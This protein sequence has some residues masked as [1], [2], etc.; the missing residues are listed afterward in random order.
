MQVTVTIETG[1]VCKQ[2]IDVLFNFNVSARHKKKRRFDRLGL[3][4]T[5]EEVISYLEVKS[6]FKMGINVIEPH[7]Y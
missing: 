7:C 4:P 6:S 1:G 3:F 2:I 5:E